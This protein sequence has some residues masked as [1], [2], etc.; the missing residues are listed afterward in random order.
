MDMLP[1]VVMA[2]AC[3]QPSDLT[4][5][6]FHCALESTSCPKDS[7]FI[8][9][10]HLDRDDKYQHIKEACDTA[11]NINIGVCVSELDVGICTGHP[12][13]CE[14]G[15]A[16]S[17]LNDQCTLETSN[18][19]D[20]VWKYPL[21]GHCMHETTPPVSDN[22]I[23]LWSD[24]D[25]PDN[26][27]YMTAFAQSTE[28]ANNTPCTCDKV[29]VGA[30]EYYPE[31]IGKVNRAQVYCAVSERA[32][33]KE[34]TYIPAPKLI[35]DGRNC[36]LCKT[37]GHPLTDQSPVA[38]APVA[39][40][41][42]VASNLIVAAPFSESIVEIPHH[43]PDHNKQPPPKAKEHHA[44]HEIVPPPK[45]V[46]NPAD[47]NIPKDKCPDI[48]QGGCNVC[49]KTGTC[50]SKIDA[51]FQ[52]PS[53]PAVQC[54]E[55]QQSGLDGLIPLALCPLLSSMTD[56]PKVCGCMPLS[57][58]HPPLAMGGTIGTEAE[59]YAAI[60]NGVQ[61]EPAT[62]DKRMVIFIATSA[63]FILFSIMILI[64]RR[65]N[66]QKQERDYSRDHDF[67]LDGP[68][69]FEMVPMYDDE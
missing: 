19:D 6:T 27:D 61:P 42:P 3:I 2:G 32:C 25:C 1:E 18:L 58:G 24:E 67:R 41:A 26:S 35:R 20:S 53:Q 15:G 65:Q 9:S 33:D 14:G 39:P 7:E 57:K 29:R 48:P 23:C 28:D 62:R 51:I 59:Y 44:E 8:S 30:C 63:S 5:S 54:G 22:G 10:R 17:P 36:F 69:T 66:K 12:S 40:L 38:P 64:W 46:M 31:E 37:S 55:L 13:N 4:L 45:I 52:Y 49:G 47:M 34:S 50:I 68:S 16:F 43:E 21:F 60:Q 56:M 11:S